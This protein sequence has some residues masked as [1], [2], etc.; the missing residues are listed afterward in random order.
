MALATSSVIDM[1]GTAAVRTRHARTF[2][3]SSMRDAASEQ[4]DD[5]DKV[6]L[7]NEG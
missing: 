1:A 2:G 7:F 3:M 5:D 4:V 6:S